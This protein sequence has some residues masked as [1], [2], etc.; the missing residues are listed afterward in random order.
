[1]KNKLKFLGRIM[2]LASLRGAPTLKRGD[3][4]HL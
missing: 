3:H 4:A 1:M 2:A